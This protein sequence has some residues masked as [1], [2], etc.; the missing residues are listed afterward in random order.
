MTQIIGATGTVGLM[1]DNKKVKM[2]RSP[3]YNF[4]FNKGTG[5]FERWGNTKEDDPTW[6]EFGPEIADIEIGTICHEGC[7]FCYKSNTPDGTNMS[8]DTFKKI[9]EKLP[10]VL[11]Q[12]AL[13]ISDIDSNPDIWN[14]MNHCRMND[15]VPNVT[16]NGSR[17]T[18]ESFD[19]LVRYCGAVAVSLYDYERCYNTIRELGSRGLKQVNIHAMLSEETYE[20]CMQ[21]MRDRQTDERLKK[22]LNAIVFLW[23]KP[24][25]RGE[26]LNQVSR[27]K[28]NALV[29][30]AMENN[31]PIGFD[32]CSA[33]NFLKCEGTE[34][35]LS[36]VEPCESTLFS[37]YINVD[38]I[39]TPCSFAEDKCDGVDVVA[40]ND[41]LTDVWLSK[42]FV[43][44][45]SEVTSNLDGNGCRMCPLYNLGC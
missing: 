36:Y 15:V 2:I 6:S 22:Y 33:S 44:F 31:I 27:E 45:R 43:K 18:P 34:Q 8:L 11:T 40:A 42:S 38:G 41:F 14:I 25:G 9:F 10:N 20:R 7:K 24:K 35:F 32:S 17:M 4:N 13:G 26:A 23:L 16:I 5:Y 1:R 37:I 3:N 28:Y 21:V 39:A 12:I 30:Y 19:N 29:K